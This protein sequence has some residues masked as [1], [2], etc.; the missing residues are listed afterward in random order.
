MAPP[1][2]LTF[3]NATITCRLRHWFLPLRWQHERQQNFSQAETSLSPV[4]LCTFKPDKQRHQGDDGATQA[5]YWHMPRSEDK[6]P[7]LDVDLGPQP[8]KESKP[9]DPTMAAL[10]P[11]RQTTT[12]TSHRIDVLLLNSFMQVPAISALPRLDSS[13]SHSGLSDP[14]HR[15]ECS[16]YSR[17][18]CCP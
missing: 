14:V 12:I 3:D 18:G 6:T 8:S 2:R 4:C 10:Y 7:C 5:C 1:R 15:R 17:Q 13:Q 11:V 16:I 9:R